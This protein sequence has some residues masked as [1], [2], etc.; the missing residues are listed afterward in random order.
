MNTLVKIL[1]KSPAIE[2]ISKAGA[3]KVMFSIKSKRKVAEYAI[4]HNL[5]PSELASVYSHVTDNMMRMWINDYK[6]GRYKLSNAV[7]VSRRIA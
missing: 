2:N 5:K 4:K 3:K 6:E 1:S 7:S